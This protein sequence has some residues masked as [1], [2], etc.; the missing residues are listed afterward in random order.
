MEIDISIVY[1]VPP[2]IMPTSPAAGRLIISMPSKQKGIRRAALGRVGVCGWV[3]G[4]GECG[5]A[6]AIG[7]VGVCVWGG[8]GAV[9]RRPLEGFNVV[10]Y[11][12][13]II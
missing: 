5:G 2:P 4:G 3:G 10:P 6:A 11:N 1:M 7:R 8:G 9:G 13:V 12:N